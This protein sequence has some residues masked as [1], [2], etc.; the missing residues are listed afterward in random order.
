[1]IEV[2]SR[3]IILFKNF[4]NNIFRFFYRDFTIYN[5]LIVKILNL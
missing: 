3:F 1:M 5:L 2:K 4:T